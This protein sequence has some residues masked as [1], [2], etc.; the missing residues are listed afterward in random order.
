MNRFAFF[1]FGPHPPYTDWFCGSATRAIVHA[2]SEAGVPRLVCVP[3][4]MVSEWEVNK[5][6]R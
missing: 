3:G 2:M 4:A 1:Y 5:H 6:G